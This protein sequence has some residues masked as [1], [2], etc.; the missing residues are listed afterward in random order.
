M[1]ITSQDDFITGIYC[2]DVRNGFIEVPESFDGMVGESIH[3]FDKTWQRCSFA[4]PRIDVVAPVL[5]LTLAEE[6]R[7]G[8]RILDKGC[9]LVGD[10]IEMMSLAEQIEA[11]AEKLPAGW[12]IL[13][14]MLVELSD[15]EKMEVGITPI[16]DGCE[17]QNGTV[18][19]I[20]TPAVLARREIG[21]IN[22]R[23]AVLD[24][25]RSRPLAA[26]ALGTQT[27][28]DNVRLKEIE[29]EAKALRARLA[30]LG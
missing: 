29:A 21:E 17:L 13:N 2:G 14:G 26:Y 9:R 27:L 16:P 1:Y 22:M 18:Q 6:I 28:T 7:R 23:F 10:N 3:C 4:E 24:L 15:Y 8:I 19:E 20:E 30:E 5:P 11:G 25:A 12:K